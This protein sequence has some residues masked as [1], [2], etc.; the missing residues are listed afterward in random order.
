MIAR[1]DDCGAGATPLQ[2]C[3]FD[4]VGLIRKQK[5]AATFLLKSNTRKA[6]SLIY[7][8]CDFVEIAL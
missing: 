8:I 4:T 3:D 5:F 7:E 2:F 1:T 6:C